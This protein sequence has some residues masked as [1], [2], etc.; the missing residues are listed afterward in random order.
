[1]I[2]R[3]LPEARRQAVAARSRTDPS[4]ASRLFLVPRTIELE[5]FVAQVRSVIDRV[6][7]SGEAVV[8]AREGTPVAVLVSNAAYRSQAVL[9]DLPRWEEWVHEM[10]KSFAR[11]GEV[12][13]HVPLPDP[14]QVDKVLL[15]FDPGTGRVGSDAGL[16][17]LAAELERLNVAVRDAELLA[18]IYAKVLGVCESKERLYDQDLRVLAQEMIAQA[19]QRLR[20]LSVTVS[21]TTGLPATAEVTLQLGH[22]PAMRREQ[23]DGPLDAALKAIQRLTGMEPG[24]EN[25][26]LV[27][28]TRGSDAIAEAVIELVHEGRR[29]IG[30]GASTNAI[31]AGIYAY[32]NA[33]NFLMEAR[34][35]N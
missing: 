15:G 35:V 22:G 9:A 34:S 1:M 13:P 8:V 11:P 27:S 33:L 2:A 23:G 20:L 5:D 31:E 24:V 30:A 3:I 7:S 28:A 12:R 19:P 14:P 10:R 26:S 21:S 32:V 16:E 17:F 6:T 4:R 25:F 29:A 18:D